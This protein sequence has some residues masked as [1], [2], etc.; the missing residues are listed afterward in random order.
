MEYR[1][2]AQTFRE[3]MARLHARSFIDGVQ[4]GS[5]ALADPGPGTTEEK[6]NRAM[7]AYFNGSQ[8][9]IGNPPPLG[10]GELPAQRRGPGRP[11]RDGSMPNTN[12]KMDHDTQ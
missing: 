5:A 6:L 3:W 11:R 8:L 1:G 2:L 9:F 12:G 10:S 7:E 4:I